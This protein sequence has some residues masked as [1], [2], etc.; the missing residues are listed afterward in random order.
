MPLCL[1]DHWA[2][3]VADQTA[4]VITYHDSKLQYLHDDEIGGHASASNIGRSLWVAMSLKFSC[5][6]NEVCLFLPNV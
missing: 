5:L 3:A 2:L 4:R 1:Q 6:F